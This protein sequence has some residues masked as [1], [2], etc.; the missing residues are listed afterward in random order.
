M[1]KSVKHHV[2]LLAEGQLATIVY[3]PRTRVEPIPDDVVPLEEGI[4]GACRILR[5]LGYDAEHADRDTASWAQVI[6][7]GRRTRGYAEVENPR[8]AQAR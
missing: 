8:H 1:D 6:W 3:W 2:L 5:G 4:W 7:S